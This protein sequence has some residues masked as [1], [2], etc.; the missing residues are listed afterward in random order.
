MSLGN[1]TGLLSRYFVLFD[2]IIFFNDNTVNFINK[3]GNV[4]KY[5]YVDKIL[6]IIS[7]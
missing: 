2:S 4:L 3:I 1:K 6:F 7:T 5:K